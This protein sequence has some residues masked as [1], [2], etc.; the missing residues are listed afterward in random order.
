MMSLLLWSDRRLSCNTPVPTRS[1]CRNCRTMNKKPSGMLR[2]GSGTISKVCHGTIV[3]QT[4]IYGRLGDFQSEYTWFGPI[5]APTLPK[6]TQK[7]LEM[8]ERGS[9]TISKG[10]LGKTLCRTYFCGRIGYY[11]SAHTRSDK[12]PTPKL[13]KSVQNLPKCSG[14]VPTPC[15]RVHRNI[16]IPTDIRSFEHNTNFN[17]KFYHYTPF[18]MFPEG[19]YTSFGNFGAGTWSDRVY[20]DEWSPIPP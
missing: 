2:S 15:R 6:S 4:Y 3:R 9:R 16:N 12:I 1:R 14:E 18:D 20:S 17:I 11:P 5:P 13:H 10:V 19:L 7:P 8:L